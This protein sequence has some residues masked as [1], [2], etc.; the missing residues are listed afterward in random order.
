MELTLPKCDSA[1]S[2]LLLR[3]SLS[4]PTN[5][6]LIEQQIIHKRDNPGCIPRPSPV[7]DF[8]VVR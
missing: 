1:D 6:D 7:L 3:E 2:L 8:R 4:I 5:F